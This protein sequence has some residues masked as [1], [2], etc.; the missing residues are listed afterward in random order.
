[1]PEVLFHKVDYTLNKLLEDIAV[2][3]IGLPDIQRPFVWSNAKVSDL[4]DPLA[5]GPKAAI[6]R[7]HLFPRKYLERLG[8]K[9]RRWVNQVAN[10]APVEWRDNVAIGDKAPSEYVPE[11]EK[12]FSQEQLQ[13][14]YF[15]HG[16]PERWYELEYSE[17]LEERRRRIAAVI[18][19]GFEQLSP[20]SEKE[21]AMDNAI[22][23]HYRSSLI[24]HLSTSCAPPKP[25][26]SPSL[27]VDSLG[28]P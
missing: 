18:R 12:R 22:H 16:L 20:L 1:M 23:V 17:F 27:A 10:F 7:H 11:Y 2:G 25:R 3:E 15:W 9:E 28:V 14:M 8:I 26:D 24:F 6:D 13:Q 19:A 5:K 4:L 21:A